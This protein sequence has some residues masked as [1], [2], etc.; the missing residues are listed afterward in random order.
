MNYI[1]TESQKDKIIDAL[2]F[3][4]DTGNARAAHEWKKLADYLEVLD[5]G[6]PI[7]NNSGKSSATR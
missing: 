1:I 7:A 3:A 2:R 6:K 4:A 5:P